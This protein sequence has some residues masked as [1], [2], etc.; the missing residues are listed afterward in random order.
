MRSGGTLDDLF[1]QPRR[2]DIMAELCGSA[3]GK[4]FSELKES[5][6]LTDGNLSRHLQA[7]EKAG[8]VKIKKGFVGS[9]PLTTVQVTTKGRERFLDYL[10]TL[11]EVLKRAAERAGAVEA[12]PVAG[13]RLK[14]VKA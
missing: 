13:R 3:A 8:A 4:S 5:L 12:V 2:L 1:H 11:E 10:A 9:K 14:T 6:D 7:L